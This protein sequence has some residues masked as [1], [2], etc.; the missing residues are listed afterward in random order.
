MGKDV[1]AF[2]V[3]GWRSSGTERAHFWPSLCPR[4]PPGMHSSLLGPNQP[5]CTVLSLEQQDPIP[6]M[7]GSHCSSSL[8]C[9]SRDP[10]LCREQGKGARRGTKPYCSP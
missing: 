6:P 5:S 7:D 1:P 10:G 3:K 2:P 4:D 9:S 8:I